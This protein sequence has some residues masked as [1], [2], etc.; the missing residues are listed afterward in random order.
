MEGK[1]NLLWFNYL[2]HVWKIVLHPK[3]DIKI[4]V[5]SLKNVYAVLAKKSKKKLAYKGSTWI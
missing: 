4:S 1:E 3:K 5:T 2:S